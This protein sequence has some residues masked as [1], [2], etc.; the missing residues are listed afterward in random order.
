MEICVLASGSSG[1]SVF[2]ETKEASVLIDAGISQRE[3]TK[4]LDNIGKDI[5]NLDAIF[6]THE[7]TD[8]IKGLLRLSKQVPVYL[9]R[10]TYDAL[11]FRITNI[12]VFQNNSDFYFKDIDL[13]PIATSHDAADPCGFR[14]Q[15]EDKIF[16]VFT[17]LGK[18]SEMIK[19]VTREAD[20]LVLETNHDVDMLINGPYPYHLKQRILGDK[21]HLSNIDAG[22]LVKENAAEKLKTVFLAHLSKNNN[23]QDLAFDTFNSLVNQNKSCRI[24]SI[25]TSQEESTEMIKI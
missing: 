3:I 23:T 19:K 25:L 22:I 16:G 5:T 18:P 4:K 21:G 12:N 1:N 15:A 9:N 14:L 7:H 6:L 20:S 17:D 13:L 2:I 10:K 8:H 24:K 11:P